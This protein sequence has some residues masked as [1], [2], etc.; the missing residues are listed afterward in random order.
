MVRSVLAVLASIDLK[1]L[2]SAASV[3]IFTQRFGIVLPNCRAGIVAGSLMVVTLSIGE[4]NM[5][6][7]L[8]TPLTPTLPVGWPMHTHRCDSSRFRLHADLFRHHH[9]AADRASMGVAAGQS[10][11]IGAR[12]RPASLAWSPEGVLARAW[13]DGAQRPAH[14]RVFNR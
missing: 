11:A 9:S 6:L 4:F 10:G 8:H 14:R 1:S 3:P 13:R 12:A 2:E 7:L 5:T